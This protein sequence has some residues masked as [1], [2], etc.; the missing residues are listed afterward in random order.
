M[1][2]NQRCVNID[3]CVCNAILSADLHKHAHVHIFSL[4]AHFR[5]IDTQQQYVFAVRARA[6]AR[7][8][9]GAWENSFKNILPHSVLINHIFQSYIL[10]TWSSRDLLIHIVGKSVGYFISIP[11]SHIYLLQIHTICNYLCSINYSYQVSA[12]IVYCA[13]N[14]AMHVINAHCKM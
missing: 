6:A 11:Q 13:C 8:P 3:T 12:Q 14:F 2:E 1:F 4:Q 9:T 5:Q 7:E 10:L